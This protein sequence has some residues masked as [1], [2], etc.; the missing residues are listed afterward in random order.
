MKSW[1]FVEDLDDTSLDYGSGY[2]NG[3][4]GWAGHKEVPDSPVPLTNCPR[5]HFWSQPAWYP[6]YPGLGVY[7]PPPSF[8]LPTPCLELGKEPKDLGS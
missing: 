6:P 7:A 2:P 8:I 1:K 3:K 4:G 5:L